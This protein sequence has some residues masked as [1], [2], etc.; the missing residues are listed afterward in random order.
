MT[1]DYLSPEWLRSAG[2]AV[3]SLVPIPSS[4]VVAVRV[5]DLPGGRA[6]VEYCLVLG[7]DR[8]DIVIGGP[9]PDV[10]LTMPYEIAAAIAQGSIGAQRAFLDGDVRLGGDTTALLG[11]QDQ[12]AE[13]EDRLGELRSRTRF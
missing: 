4:V 8:V 3:A 6:D 1:I 2:Q 7:P 13:I 12:L 5:V 9:D 10:S 11:H